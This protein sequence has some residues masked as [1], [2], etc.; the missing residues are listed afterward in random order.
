LFA[1]RENDGIEHGLSVGFDFFFF[2]V[3]ALLLAEV[4]YF[5]G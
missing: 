4:E 5:L 1:L 2:V 3:L